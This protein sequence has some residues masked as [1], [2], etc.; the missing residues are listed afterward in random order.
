MSF[1][2]P[3]QKT[4]GTSTFEDSYYEDDQDILLTTSRA[5]R[6]KNGRKSSHNNNHHS[7]NSYANASTET[8]SDLCH[9]CESGS[10][11][12]SPFT[13]LG[14]GYFGT[15]HTHNPLAAYLDSM[16]DEEKQ[17]LALQQTDSIS[18]DGLGSDSTVA[19]GGGG[20][21]NKAYDPDESTSSIAS[22]SE[23]GG[24]A[25]PEPEVTTRSSQ[26]KKKKKA[27]EVVE[28]SDLTPPQQPKIMSN[29]D[30]DF[31]VSVNEHKKGIR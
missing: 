29:K 19:P 5:S 27:D 11:V 17:K 30:K 26:K 25:S 4:R 13:H 23:A 7:N 9:L 20:H 16:A 24:A 3:K 6:K 15:R 21:D 18:S 22:S 8:G 14:S 28:M 2:D 12:V 31:Y 1:D 10:E